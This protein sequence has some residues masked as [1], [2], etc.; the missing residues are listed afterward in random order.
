MFNLHFKFIYNIKNYN[1][2]NLNNPP[3]YVFT[4]HYKNELWSLMPWI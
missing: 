2:D 1:C 4:L 3:N